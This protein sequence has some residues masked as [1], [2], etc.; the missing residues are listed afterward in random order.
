[1]RGEPD[2]KKG[3][4]HQLVLHVPTFLC[5]ILHI[6][7]KEQIFLFQLLKGKCDLLRFF[8]SSLIWTKSQAI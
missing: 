5:V 8:D 1:M 6:L 4:N 3:K 2:E 7:Y